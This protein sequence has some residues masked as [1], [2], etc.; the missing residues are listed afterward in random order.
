MSSTNP[1]RTPNQLP[2]DHV[3]ELSVEPLP[4]L[5]SVSQ[6]AVLC[7]GL[8]LACAYFVDKEDLPLWVRLSIASIGMLTIGLG[9]Y[10]V[11]RS[12]TG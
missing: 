12:K 5:A 4:F 8:G 10:R 11:R 7:G 3:G 9:V 2:A 1:Y 6:C